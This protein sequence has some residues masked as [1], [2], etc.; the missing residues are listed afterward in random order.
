LQAEAMSATRKKQPTEAKQPGA[1]AH[2]KHKVHALWPPWT[3]G[4]LVLI[5]GELAHHFWGRTLPSA[6]IV[7]LVLVLTTVGL[8]ALTHRY[9]APRKP[10]QQWHAVLSVAVLGLSLVLVEMFG[11][12]LSSWPPVPNVLGQVV[13]FMS[14]VLALSWNIRRFEV[15]RGTGDDK[16]GQDSTEEDWHGLKKPRLLKVT[17]TSTK[18]TRAKVK[19]AAGQTAKDVEAALGPVGSDLG[20]VTNG[21]RV[22]RGAMEGEVDLTLLWED[23]LTEA[24]GWDGPEHVGGSI[25]DPISLGVN[26]QGKKVLLNMGGGYGNDDAVP[27]HVKIIGMPRSG[28]G[29]CVIIIWTNLR[30]R[31]DVYPVINDA[32]K[33]EQLL[34]FLRPGMPREKAWIDTT[35]SGAKVQAQA[36]LR[37]VSARNKALGD[38]GFSSW[39][40]KAFSEGFMWKG[41]RIHMPAIVFHVEEFAPVGMAS[42]NLFTTIG[43]QALSAGI[44][45]IVSTQRASHD[46]FP[47]SLRSLIPN[48]ICYGAHDD[49]DVSFALPDGATDGG[50]SPAQWQTKYKGRAMASLNGQPDGMERIPFKTHYAASKEEFEDYVK[51]TM[52]YLGRLAPD[53]DPCTAEA[54]GQPYMDY[55]AGDDTKATPPPK[56]VT[57]DD[58]EDDEDPSTGKQDED[59]MDDDDPNEA[60]YVK[61]PLPEGLEGAE[62]IDPRQPLP[63]WQGPDIDLTPPPSPGHWRPGHNPTPQE[64][65]ALFREILQHLADTGELEVTTGRLIE[66]WTEALGNPRAKQAATVGR[67]IADAAAEDLVDGEPND[68]LGCLERGKRG[69]FRITIRPRVAA[70]NGHRP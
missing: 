69:R 11:A 25:A 31:R 38:A 2:P 57:S 53:L 48:G 70:L 21:I 7:P 39:E 66:L 44:F 13:L 63:E 12:G 27:G 6:G 10:V 51:E 68:L 22:E 40:P 9:A 58:D 54:F 67:F 30:A 20:T 59:D 45:L 26:E 37:A 65:R 62:H 36:V 43:E 29:V 49:T 46:R 23:P 5:L 24:V 33:G 41:Q 34:M 4:P 32:A 14:A 52:P 55:L 8:S 28:K 15:V 19:L 47:T 60:E 17:E 35:L 50:A 1:A 61:P 64:K 16:H 56:T 18:Q 42:P 3:A